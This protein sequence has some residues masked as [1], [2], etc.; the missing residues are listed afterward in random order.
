M[1][2]GR[3]LADLG[4]EAG[5]FGEADGM[6]DGVGGTHAPSPQFDH[7]DTDGAGVD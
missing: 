4:A 1:R 2:E 3:V 5:E 6:I 7:R